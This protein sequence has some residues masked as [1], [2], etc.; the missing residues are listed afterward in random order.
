MSEQPEGSTR[1]M[2]EDGTQ[3]NPESATPGGGGTRGPSLSTGGEQEPGGPV[4]P[5]D[6][7]QE[8][9]K[10]DPGTGG[11]QDSARV[12]GAAAPVSSGQESGKPDPDETPRGAVAS[13]A[14]ELPAGE[15]PPG[16]EQEQLDPGVGPAHQAGTARGED[17]A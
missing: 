6:G 3:R 4:P 15:T 14:E 17:Q 16:G 5:Y 12:G 9:A 8:S 13:P 1:D 10:P 11:H 7:R 2:A